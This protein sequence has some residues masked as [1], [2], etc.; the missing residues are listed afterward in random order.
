MHGRPRKSLKSASSR[1]FLV[2]ERVGDSVDGGNVGCVD[3]IGDGKTEGRLLRDIV[4]NS[5]GKDEGDL[6]G[7]LIGNFVGI[8]LGTMLGPH[9]LGEI[10]KFIE[11]IVQKNCCTKRIHKKCMNWTTYACRQ[12]K[13][14][15]S[16]TNLATPR[17]IS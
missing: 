15:N 8:M 5:V 2:G 17:T 7:I 14:Y 6:L 11:Y 1:Q 3:G 13:V 12:N 4:G 10:E 16:L 9:N